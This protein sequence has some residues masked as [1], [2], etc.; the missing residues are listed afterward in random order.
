MYPTTLLL[1]VAP[2]T[3][4]AHMHL[5]QPVPFNLAPLRRENA[6]IILSSQ[7]PCNPTNEPA[8]LSD[9]TTPMTVGQKQVLSIGGTVPH[10]GGSCQLSITTDAIPTPNSAFKVIKS[11]EGGCP[12]PT[13][14][15][16]EFNFEIPAVVPNGEVTLAWSWLAQVT[17][18]F[19][20]N[21]APITVSGGA[22][23]ASGLEK[24]PDMLVAS[25]DVTEAECTFTSHDTIFPDPG[26]VVEKNGDASKAAKP[27]GAG[28]GK[29]FVGKNI[30]A[31]KAANSAANS[32]TTAVP[33]PS[34]GAGGVFAPG[35]SSAA[36]APSPSTSTLTTLIAVTATPSAPESPSSVVGT[37]PAAV[38]T[39]TTTSCPTD[40]M[41]VCNGTEQFG[42]CDHGKAVWQAVAAGTKCQ[43]GK[44]VKREFRAVRRGRIPRPRFGHSHF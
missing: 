43:D 28:C 30:G 21:C 19:Y 1:L 23:D 22:K 2:L 17:G 5:E 27:V 25:K 3:T 34:G 31:P 29:T 14:T 11:F 13:D 7:Y 38:G 12:D 35:A 10:G 33:A 36:E 42:L 40:G 37:A 26:E 4:L 20:M 6:P 39:G 18:E 15:T 32:A 44:V 24:L 8:F 41:V 9:T 16:K